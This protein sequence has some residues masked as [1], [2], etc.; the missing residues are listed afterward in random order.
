LSL[1]N[2]VLTVIYTSNKEAQLIFF[3]QKKIVILEGDPMYSQLVEVNDVI[4]W[5]I[6]DCWF[7]IFVHPAAAAFHTLAPAHSSICLRVPRRCA[8]VWP[9]GHG[10]DCRTW[11]QQGYK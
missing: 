9:I 8:R 1:R 6:S 2:Y 5:K 4:G 3:R 10:E 11:E 7:S